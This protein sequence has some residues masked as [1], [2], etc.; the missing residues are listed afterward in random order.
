LLTLSEVTAIEGVE[1]DFTVS[2]L[3]KPRYVDIDK[4]IA[5]GLCAQKCPKK[6]GDEYNENLTKRKAIYV[7][8]SQ[9]VPL[10]YAID[11]ENCIHFSKGKCG[12]CETHCPS[13]AINFKDTAREIRLQVGS[14]ILAP[15]FRAFD[16]S[17]F[18]HYA[19][20]GLPD[21]VTSLEFER[22]L[23]ATGPFSGHLLRPS[24]MRGKKPIEKQ[25][26]K[27]AW[28]QCVGSRDINRCDNGY[29]SSVCCMYAVKQA[30]MAKEHAKSALDCVIFNMDIRT[31]GKDFDRYYDNA[32]KK[33]VRFVHARIHTVD[34]VP[35]SADLLLRY[36][37]DD[38]RQQEERFDMVV[39]STGLEVRPDAIALAQA[40]GVELDRYHF[41]RTD[42]FHPVATSRPGIYAC[43]A[44]A[45]PK[46]I[47]QS[48][49]EASA[50]ACAATEALAAA[51][52]TRTRSVNIPA[53]RDVSREAPRI[54]VFVCNC[55][56]NIGG[57]VRVPEV[58]EHA[59]TLPG[60]VYVEENLFTCSQDTQDKI[61][62][63]IREKTL[64][65]VVVAA[66]TPRTHEALFQETLIN[67][68]LNKYLIEMANIRNQDAW[69]HAENP[70]AATQKAK[71]L[72]RM[73]V[74]NASFSSPLQETEL[75]V[76]RSALVVGA[77]VAGMTAA[78]SL[79]RHGY[80][81]H[82]V[83]ASGNLG[84]NARRLNKTFRDED[85]AAFLTD[86]IRQVEAEPRLTVH[87][88]AS[89]QRVDG[90]V[91]NFSS[92]I[93]QRDSQ[94]TVEHGIAILALGAQES[95]PAEYL[96]GEHAAVVTGLEMDELLRKQDPRVQKA[97]NVVF[98]QCVGSR[99]AERPYCSK[100]CC[101]HSIQSALDLK[102]LNPEIN[103]YILYRD[104]RTYGAREDLYREA[105]RRGVLFFRYDPDE[106]PQVIANDERVTVQF[107]DA[108]IGRNLLVDADILC[109]AAAIVPRDH[110]RLVQLFKVPV[111]SDGWLLEAHQKLQPVEFA[112]EGVFLCGMGHYPKPIEE[113]IAQ[114]QAA[115]AKALTVLARQQ[116]MV[117]GKVA[118]IQA[119]WCSGCLGCIQVCPYGAI[120]FNAEKGVAEI[121][122]ALCK[123]CGACAAACPSEAPLLAGFSNRQIYAQIRSATSAA[124]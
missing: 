14:L 21:V 96:H 28:L 102:T 68:G 1:G 25:P 80:P 81:V 39:L 31:Q 32:R 41:T 87:L 54:G 61:T 2:V 67:A 122:Q 73:A 93:S 94:L 48:V 30:V 117:G 114:A 111:D 55:G 107:N 52:H 90:F 15:G 95:K 56:I 11:A 82:L 99:N 47:P 75:P 4:C 13:G 89:I 97:Q 51:R 76:S 74:A 110:Q 121:N 101:T 124:A 60:V 113:S 38:G 65:R 22:I 20:L 106:K 33:G 112:T 120:T 103:V 23:S 115:A 58:A 64:N 92:V 3:Q 116:I 66:C 59:R 70:Q 98:I 71:D 6:V 100:V 16:P 9:A 17:R 36:V 104:I 12:A 42:S 26:Q 29:C 50:A 27:I 35:G 105:R 123:G 45:G 19:Y 7:P 119:E 69:V 62:T 79:A 83:E 77:G 91:G 86:L 84:G 5:C 53:Q 78:L 57:I 46:D 118:R 8:Y 108:I 49:M 10:K 40:A 72:V 43:G 24:G 85:I 88:G 109:L 18:D 37:A 63:V 44:F 34:P